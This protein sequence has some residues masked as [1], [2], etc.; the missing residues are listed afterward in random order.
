MA[1][2][3]VSSNRV[4]PFAVGQNW[5]S[6]PFSVASRHAMERAK[7]ATATGGATGIERVEQMRDRGFPW[8]GACIF[9]GQRESFPGSRRQDTNRP[10]RRR[11]FD[12]VSQKLIDSFPQLATIDREPDVSGVRGR[13]NHQGPN[14]E[15]WL[16]IRDGLRDNFRHLHTRG[17]GR[18]RSGVVHEFANDV[19]DTHRLSLN[20][21]ERLL[22][23]GVWLRFRQSLSVPCNHRERVVDLVARTGCQLCESGKFLIAYGN[24]E[25]LA[26]FGQQ[27]PQAVDFRLGSAQT[28]FAFSPSSA[29]GCSEELWKQF[30]RARIAGEGVLLFELLALAHTAG[31]WPFVESASVPHRHQVERHRS[32]FARES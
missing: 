17:N 28:R 24:L 21:V 1:R 8:A 22:P 3:N 12:G 18:G 31:G 32:Q 16:K 15:L 5:S 27:F 19:A 11:G 23:L 30:E 29:S 14:R 4:T 25:L 6:P 2:G 20:R 9:D 10:A 26:S 7:P 13:I